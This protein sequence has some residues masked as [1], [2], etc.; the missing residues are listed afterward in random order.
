ML[1]GAAGT[2]SAATTQTWNFLGVTFSDGGQMTGSFDLS[3]TGVVS[4]V[5]ITTSGGNTGSFGTTFEYNDSNSFIGA[6]PWTAGYLI[7]YNQGNRYLN[8][9]FNDVSGAPAGTHVALD[10]QSYECTNCGVVRNVTSGSMV[11]GPLTPPN[12]TG[13]PTIAP[14]G[15]ATPQVGQTLIG[16]DSTVTATPQGATKTYRWLRDGTVIPGATG[17][18]YALTNDDAGHAI[19]FGVGASEADYP[20]ATPVASDPVGPVDGGQITLP[21][22]EITGTPVVDGLLSAALPDGLDPTDANVAWQWSRGDVPVGDGLSS[23]SPTAADAGHLLTVTATATKDHF[24]TTDQSTNTAE[25]AIATFSQAPAPTISGTIKVGQTLTADSGTVTPEPD[26]LAYQWYSDGD[27]ISGATDSTYVLQGAQRHTTITVQVTASKAGYDDAGATSDPTGDVATDVAPDVSFDVAHSTIRRGQSTTLDWSTTDADT[28][29]ASGAWAGAKPS[30]GTADVAPV[31][32]GGNTYVLA[33]TNANGTTTSQV[34]V[35]VTRPVALLSVSAPSGLHLTGRT[36]AVSTRGLEAD[37]TYAIVIDGVR[38]ATGR[39]A[40]GG[41]LTRNVT[42]PAAVGD[43]A[44]RVTV[45]G[46]ESDRTGTTYVQVVVRKTL[47]LSVAKKVMHKRHRQWVNV[48]GLVA[49]EHVAVGY[50]GKRVSPASAYADAN[51]TYRVGIRV[52]RL[53]GTKT[54]TATGAF[55]GRHAVTTFR[56]RRH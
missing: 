34:V 35:T 15:T 45:T 18:T 53:A 52:G 12:V 36:I 49:G 42:V 20:D 23:Y 41:E 1:L 33:A 26:A 43:H 28:V 56:V 48:T 39:T 32:L 10:R 46:S 6:S 30:A 37:E 9:A 47:G 55:H 17:T 2:A 21:S 25:V 13:T 7:F 16:D 22:P 4:A 8:L 11:A 38:V 50:R 31:N 5:H 29:T 14:T 40:S 3:D 44:A 24:T 51:G 27:P 54:V 19:V